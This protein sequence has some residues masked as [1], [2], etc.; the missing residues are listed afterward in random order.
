[1]KRGNA[2]CAA[3]H[4]VDRQRGRDTIKVKRNHVQIKQSL[5]V[6]LMEHVC[7]DNTQL[8]SHCGLLVE[9]S[10]VVINLSPG[11]T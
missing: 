10:Q 9:Q 6:F 5:K 7:D 4:E 1:M 3:R 11:G 8:A 2:L